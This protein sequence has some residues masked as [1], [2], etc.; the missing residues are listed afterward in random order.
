M[1]YDRV[2]GCYVVLCMYIIT[3]K[4]KEYICITIVLKNKCFKDE[5]LFVLP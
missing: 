2:V 3:G 5:Y 1:G 4:M